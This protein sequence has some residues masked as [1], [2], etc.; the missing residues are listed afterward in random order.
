MVRK[1]EKVEITQIK[2]RKVM[3]SIVG[4]TPIIVHRFAVKAW[5]ELLLPSRKK[6]RAEREANLKH[7]PVAEFRGCLYLNRNKQTPTMFHLPSGMIH[8]STAAAALDMP[9]ATRASIER[10]VS[11]STPDLFLYGLPY[12]KADMIRNSDPNRTPDVR[13]RPC[14]PRWCIKDIQ[15]EYK[16]DPLNDSQILNLV[17]AAGV[18]C[19]LG[20]YRPQKGGTFGKFRLAEA[21]DAELLDIVKN[22]G[23]AAQ[24]K[25]FDAAPEYDD[26]T[27]ELM[28]WFNEEIAR[29][30]QE[31]PSAIDGNGTFVIDE[32]DGEELT[33]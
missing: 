6:N 15:M 28:S 11:V 12:L 19:G 27:S 22:E 16:V 30:E 31:L 21:N 26:D 33:Q 20:D 23:R 9:G 18:I 7:D 25:N 14:L 4:V 8:Q 2:T 29:R 10:L 32:D 1:V 17:A 13:I 24:Q 3:F 5:R